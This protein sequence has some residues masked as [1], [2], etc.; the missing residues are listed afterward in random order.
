M[1][2]V[3]Y[4]RMRRLVIGTV[5]SVVWYGWVSRIHGVVEES[6]SGGVC[7]RV[8]V[9]RIFPQGGSRWIQL[10]AEPS[11]I[12]LVNRSFVIV[13]RLPIERVCG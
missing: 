11:R 3:L 7:V 6:M 1:E 9:F 13:D 12:R 2:H 10:V 8:N 4:G 5:W